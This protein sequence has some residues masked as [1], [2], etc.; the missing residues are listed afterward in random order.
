MGKNVPDRGESTVHIH[1]GN[2][3]HRQGHFKW[4][5]QK[6][7]HGGSWQGGREGESWQEITGDQIRANLITHIKKFGLFLRIMG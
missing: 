6:C 7:G 3:D 1:K 4:P 2:R 5:E